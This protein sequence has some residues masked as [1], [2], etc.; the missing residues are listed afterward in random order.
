MMSKP[1]AVPRAATCDFCASPGRPL[2]HGGAIC[3]DCRDG[4]GRTCAWGAAL[5]G[6]GKLP[7]WVVTVLP[8][9]AVD[10]WPWA[11]ATGRVD[12]P[13]CEHKAESLAALIPHLNSGHLCTREQIADFVD[14]Q[15]AE[16]F[17]RIVDPGFK[18]ASAPPRTLLDGRAGTPTSDPPG[19]LQEVA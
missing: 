14:D 1:F 5:D 10:E 11:F 16:A 7:G 4:M 18:L 2:P 6:I 17:S 12:C 8:G 3:D 9:A 13:L 15:E 19:H